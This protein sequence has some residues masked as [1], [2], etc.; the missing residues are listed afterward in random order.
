VCDGGLVIDLS[1]M[2]GV[3]VDPRGR[4]ARAGRGDLGR[5]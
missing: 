5:L 3:H 2:R 1:N 4:R